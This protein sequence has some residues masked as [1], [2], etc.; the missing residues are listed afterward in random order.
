M[1]TAYLFDE[2]RG[3]SVDSWTRAFQ[4]LSDDQVLWLDLA[5]PSDGE[6]E[7]IAESLEVGDVDLSDFD[8]PERRPRFEQHD[9]YL[10]LTVV[11]VSDKQRDPDQELVAVDCFVGSNWVL[12]SHTA[13]VEA[14]DDFREIVSGEGEIGILDAPS[15]LAALLEWVV[16]SYLRAFDE[17]EATLE[18]LDV[19]AL[20]APSSH[21][22]KQIRML[23]EARRRVGR[24]RRAL[25]PHRELFAALSHFEF[26][27]I[28]TERS[29]S[30]FT[31]L[32]GR[33]DSALNS[34]RDAKDGIASSFDV[35]I[36]RTE[37]RTNEIMKA[38]ARSSSA[39]PRRLARAASRSRPVSG[40][41]R[42]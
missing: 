13:A 36:V 2:R 11:A 29:A 3:E 42:A 25:A 28:S 34:A 31:E 41:S 33:V 40:S 8:A 19:G 37:H 12:S 30:R 24:L 23:I 17:I 4:D 27:P 9:E 15:F 26:D 22:E 39:S 32:M 38:R 6:L 16:T 20:E 35:L 21:P 5:S 10:G 7:E 14:L 18:D 1:Q